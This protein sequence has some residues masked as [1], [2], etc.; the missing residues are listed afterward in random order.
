[1]SRGPIN[2]NVIKS[3]DVISL[4]SGFSK[5]AT[6]FVYNGATL[7][8]G[9]VCGIGFSDVTAECMA[10]GQCSI[11]NTSCINFPINDAGGNTSSMNYNIY[12]CTVDGSGNYSI[13]VNNNNPIF[14]GQ[15]VTFTPVNSIASAWQT[16][17]DQGAGV[18]ND[19]ILFNNTSNNQ[20]S[21]YQVWA[22]V[23]PVNKDGIISTNSTVTPVNST[24]S[25][26]YG[27]PYWI[28][29]VGKARS[30]SANYQFATLNNT[31]YDCVLSTQDYSSDPGT[32]NYASTFIFCDASGSIPTTT[33]SSPVPSAG[34]YSSS[35]F[36][37]LNIIGD[38]SDTV[39]VIIYIIFFV[40]ITIV[41]AILLYLLL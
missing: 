8:N 3:G 15:Y 18:F 40:I 27:N 19:T 22:I 33:G 10:F 25:P 34:T 24:Y 16:G 38:I 39:Q 28:Q 14:F 26:Y 23:N 36:L 17:P 11:D 13:D 2:A 37:G 5:Y 41:L 32:S 21:E 30:D 9:T 31:G 1:M 4:A 6:N 12:A 20:L 7:N 35:G 29:S